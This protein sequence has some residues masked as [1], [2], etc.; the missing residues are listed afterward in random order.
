MPDS[1]SLAIHAC[2]RQLAF[3]HHDPG[4]SDD[5]ID[6]MIQMAMKLAA[7]TPLIVSGA[8]EG[9]KISFD[10]VDLS[11]VRE[12]FLARAGQAKASAARR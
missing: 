7:A 12:P 8:V 10:G 3:F 2:V 5:Q 9:E 4:H 11:L 6:G 1:V